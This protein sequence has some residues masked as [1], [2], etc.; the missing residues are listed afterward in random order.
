MSNV[1]LTCIRG[2]TT[3][4]D[5]AVVRDTQPVDLT[6]AKIWMTG[7]RNRG[8]PVIFQRT[9]ESGM[10][11]TIDPDQVSNPGVAIIKL[12]VESTSGLA[13]ED[14]VCYYEDRKSTRLNS[15][16]IQKSRMPSSA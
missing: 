1:A 5:L 4:W 7:R 6:G 9:T 2:D 10:G 8:G 12:A 13:S 11:I 16:H 15:S 3:E 14:T